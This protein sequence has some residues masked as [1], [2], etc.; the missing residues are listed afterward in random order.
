MR[1]LMMPDYRTGNPYQQLLAD[2]IEKAGVEVSF[3]RGYRRGLP[4]FRAVR[5]QH[6]PIDVLH[7][8]WLEP[9]INKPNPFFEWVYTLKCL[10][11]ILLTRLSG[12]RLVWTI[13]NQIE[14]DSVFPWLERW[15]RHVLMK[16]A[17]CVIVHNQSTVEY[18]AQEYTLDSRKLAVIP[19]GHYRTTYSPAIDP[20]EARKQL[21]LPL[22]GRLYLHLGALRPYKGIEHLLEVWQE[23]QNSLSDA[24][25]LIAGCC[26]DPSYLQKL[27]ALAAQ[28]NRVIFHPAFIED[29]QIHL[30]FSA[31]DFVVLPYTRILT[32]GSVILA[33]SFNKPV[34]APRLG[35]IPEVL[36]AADSLLYDPADAQGLS[37]SIQKSQDCQ[38]EEFKTLTVQACD[39]LDWDAIGQKT[40]GCFLRSIPG[41]Q[42]L[43]SSVEPKK[44]Q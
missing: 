33:M 40:V 11:D 4:I 19:H 29:E 14:H 30:Y 8:H 43:V 31:A 27:Q 21:A 12:T 7:L 9:Y 13:H 38:L 34:I 36:G 41:R 5:E 6:P 22:G 16:L 39:R 23:N 10:F 28:T 42:T 1:V 26:Y 2:A 44:G 24:S 15:L 3:A 18:L 37:R 35:A 25:L 17:D 20:V 32:S